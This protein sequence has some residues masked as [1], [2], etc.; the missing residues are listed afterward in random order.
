MTSAAAELRP[1]IEAERIESLEVGQWQAVWRRL[2]RHRFAVLGMVVV[3]CFAAIALFAPLVAPYG[4]DDQNLLDRYALPSSQH[5][6]GTDDLGRDVLTRLMYGA[7]ISLFVAVSTTLLATFIGIVV[8]AVAGY[9][10]GYVE[11]VLMRFADI[12]LSLPALPVL[13]IFAAALGGDF[14]PIFGKGVATMILVLTIFGWM[15]VARLTHGS[16]L[17]LRHREFTEAARALGGATGHIILRHMLPNSLAPIIVAATL[18]LGTRI[19]LEATLSFL[20]LGVNPPTPS[21]GNMLQNAQGY[22]W[23]Q[24]WLAIWPGACIFFTVLAVNFLG[25]GLRDALDPRLKI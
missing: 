5:W 18:G 6:F 1:A 20:G 13:I 22:I 11:M 8:G 21:W 23:S 16:V 3:A 19:I 9:V 12:M 2:R 4:F 24:P 17:S 25:D 10:G 15:V 7:R 14:L